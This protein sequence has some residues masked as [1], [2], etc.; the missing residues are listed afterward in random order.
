[1][2]CT[3]ARHMS[4]TFR[5][6]CLPIVLLLLVGASIADAASVTWNG[7][8]AQGMWTG[9]DENFY[10]TG[11]GGYIFEV[12]AGGGIAD[13]WKFAEELEMAED[14]YDFMARNYPN[15]SRSAYKTEIGNLCTGFTGDHGHLW[16]SNRYNDDMIWAVNAFAR[17]YVIT[18]NGTWLTDAENNFEAVWNRAQPGGVTDGSNGLEQITDSTTPPRMYANVNYAFVIAGNILHDIT[19]NALYK[20]QAD[21]VYSWAQKYLY[22]YNAAPAQNGSGNICSRIYNFNDTQWGGVIQ[23]RDV[24]YNYGIAIDAATR[25]GDTTAAETVANWTMYNVDFD[26]SG[27][28]PY[29]GTYAG[30]NVLPNYVVGTDNNNTN[31]AGYDGICLRGF[32]YALRQG[33]LTNPDALPWAQANLQSAWNHRGIQNLEWNDWQTVNSGTKYSWGDSSALAGMFDIPAPGG[34][35]IFSDDFSNGTDNWTVDSGSWSIVGTKP[36]YYKQSS[37]TVNSIAHVKIS[38]SAGWTDYTVS[39]DMTPLAWGSGGTG[40]ISLSLYFQDTKDRY[41]AVL[42]S[43]GIGAI[44]KD[45]SGTQTILSSGMIGPVNL[46][47]TYLV[48]FSV[49]NTGQLTMKVN[50][51]QIA[52]VTDASL[53]QSGTISLSTS[54]ASVKFTNVAVTKP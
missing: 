43:S 52:Q 31:D 32:G 28:Q 2:Y 19:G 5:T 16:T 50:G 46:N 49:T 35:P 39:A 20:T 51:T 23:V 42:G 8:N 47:T 36:Y 41:I 48:Q 4:G 45:V 17:A 33:I 13:F 37:T 11:Y 6:I 44:K 27:G 1:M 15:Q 9:Y 10:V 7:Y 12:S 22:V 25:E 53:T 18:G 30:Y 38:G 54:T 21:A 3:A 14:G 24:M 34:Y 26:N 40:S 29:N